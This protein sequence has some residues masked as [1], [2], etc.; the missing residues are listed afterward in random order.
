MK[1]RFTSKE[2]E[3]FKVAEMPAV[4]KLIEDMKEDTLPIDSYAKQ[5]LN[6]LFD[7][8]GNG[9][10]IIRSKATVA[11][12]CRIWDRFFDGSGD[13]DIWIEFLAFDP[14]VGALDCGVYLSDIWDIPADYE[15]RQRYA[16]RLKERMYF[17]AYT[18]STE[19]ENNDDK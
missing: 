19:T 7:F 9:Y 16:K 2:K 1:I 13:I 11:K 8:K 5:V 10:E 3:I 18:K 14:L 6:C 15:E 4:R 17:T 12:N